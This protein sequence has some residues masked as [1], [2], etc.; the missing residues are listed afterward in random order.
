M[1]SSTFFDKE[2]RTNHEIE[3]PSERVSAS[4]DAAD[5]QEGPDS[6]GGETNLETGSPEELEWGSPE[7]PGNP[8][9]WSM[10]KKVLHTAIP[11]LYGFVM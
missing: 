10:M 6:P 2:L 7:D 11:A 1:P 8:R 5:K 3:A 4:I 9:N